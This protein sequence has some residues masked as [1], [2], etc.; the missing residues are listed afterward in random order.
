MPKSN[1]EQEEIDV[2]GHSVKG[3][4]SAPHIRPPS[5]LQ[6]SGNLGE[7]WK[8]FR[9]K[10][11]I[12]LV[13]SKSQNEDSEY[14]VSLL[15]S[16]IGDRALKVFNN[17]TYTGTESAKDLKNVLSKFDN[18]FLP[19]VNVTFERHNFFLREQ[20]DN[21]PIDEYVTDLRDLSSTCDFGSLTDSLIKDRIVLGIKDRA[22]KDRLLRTKDLD[23]NKA[24]DIC[25]ASEISKHQLSEICTGTSTD[26]GLSLHKIKATKP[27]KQWSEKGK[28]NQYKPTS[29]TGATRK[30]TRP[31][32]K[33]CGKCGYNHPMFKCPAYGK[34]CIK[35]SRLNHFSSQCKNKNVSSLEVKSEDEPSGDE[36]Y[37][38]CINE[39][40]SNNEWSVKL[41][42]NDLI[43]IPYKLDSGAQVSVLTQDYLDLLEIDK[44]NLLPTKIKL[45]S[46]TGQK[47]SVL[48][49]CYLDVVHKG[50]THK[51]PFYV[52]NYNAP[53]I[54]G[55]SACVKLKLISRLDYM[56][57]KPSEI[58]LAHSHKSKSGNTNSES[59]LNQYSD[60]FEGV[61]CFKGECSI[62]LKSDC[63]PVVHAPRKVPLALK[64]RLKSKL[65][66]LV[67]LKIV[68]KVSEPT[69]WV[70]SL[71][72]VVKPNG[73]LRLCIDPKDLNNVILRP[74]FQMPTFDDI[75]CKLSG[76]RFFSTLDTK[77]GFWHIKLTKESS[78]LCTFNTPFG[79][80]RF[81][82]LPYGL[83][84]ASE[85]FQQKMMQI[86]DDMDGVEVYVDDIIIWGATKKQ[87]DERLKLVLD[88][89]RS[90]NIK[91]NYGK[92]KIAITELNYLGHRINSEGI[93]M[94]ESKIEAI[95]NM[96]EPKDK[97]S[98]QQFLGLITYVSKFIPKLSEHTAPLRALLKKNVAFVWSNEQQVKFDLLK[99]LLVSKPVLQFFDMKKPVTIT[100][101]SSSYALGASLLQN[102]LPVAYASKALNDV[103]Q[104]Y[105]QIEKET[106]A[107]LF[108]C[109][110]FRQYVYGTHFTVE[111]DHK[112]LISIFKK[113]ID[114]CP[115]R[116]QRMLIKLQGYSFDLVYKKGKDLVIADLLSRAN[117]DVSQPVDVDNQTQSIEAHVCTVVNSINVSNDQLTK[118]KKLTNE[119]ET[120]KILKSYIVTNWPS[121]K[122]N[123][124]DNV[125]PFWKVKDELT[126]GENLVFKGNA[127]VIPHDLR[128]EMLQRLH[129]THCGVTKTV[130]RAKNVVYWPNMEN[131]IRD[132]ISQCEPCI[133]FA[134]NYR[135]EPL[136]PHDVPKLP[137]YKVGLDIFQL[138]GKNYLLVVDY[139]SKYPELA[140]LSNI[141]TSNIVNHLK[142]IF[143]RQGI[144]KEIFADSG[145]QFTSEEFKDF[146]KEW[147]FVVSLSSPYHHQSNGMV[148]RAIQTIKRTLKKTMVEKTDPYLVMLEYRNTP[149]GNGLPS[150]AEIL[151][152][153]RLR[154]ILPY[155][156]VHLKPKIP[157]N[158]CKNLKQ[159]QNIQKFYYDKKA[160]PLRKLYKG[161]SV[162]V[163]VGSNWVKAKVVNVD[164]RLR[165]YTVQS[166]NGKFYHRNR[167]L[168][169]PVKS[170]KDAEL[171]DEDYSIDDNQTP[172]S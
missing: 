128:R 148:E 165:S 122:K 145:S 33:V 131:Q 84:C 6:W 78:Q 158:V 138:N 111:S 126:L 17:F 106:L 74:H 39:I 96:A 153:R 2:K 156:N 141:T 16:I 73:E 45:S 116:L 24:L 21:E 121:H 20:K 64:S 89:L 162:M 30:S 160:R 172:R 117:Y 66:E 3:S 110:R 163:K 40:G 58:G 14:Q 113:N 154:G 71:V 10:F 37:L 167:I 147:G 161:E 53:C 51:L 26:A 83:C 80:Y 49:L 95:T 52:V 76:A 23:L 65:D 157:S 27:A 107:I 69:E 125:K 75:S 132:M 35:C 44:H 11:E 31:M 61:G 48:G 28:G 5:E 54:L 164:V 92:C 133:T 77:N 42:T 63:N 152:N 94:D 88:K 144:P 134:N 34:R 100:V 97:K 68:D 15:L 55:L 72:I 105:S 146:S 81:L 79:R 25:R 59:I 60:L 56:T 102:N 101:D 112:P 149:L 129:F 166:E 139:Y 151:Y 140:Y 123:V 118:L 57:T 120:M 47:L 90:E 29:S 4:S 108:G 19:E 91:L 32:G 119:D 150:P 13:A 38:G 115:P 155:Q 109:E 142:Q 7:N 41:L 127:L 87:H 18:Y 12:Y 104:Q 98:L 50:E 114:S 93:H 67:R 22:V 36:L 168:L 143:S 86:F 9:Q 46:Y 171:D 170:E 159:R 85:I 82:R 169:R 43:Y 130:L 137:W 1:N 135:K 136:V 103:Q 124:P 8:F 70:N 62:K 99:K